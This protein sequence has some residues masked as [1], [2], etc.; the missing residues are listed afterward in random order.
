MFTNRK[1][2]QLQEEICDK[3]VKIY[4]LNQENISLKG[5]VDFLERNMNTAIDDAMN[6]FALEKAEMKGQYEERI[7]M[8]EAEIDIISR[9]NHDANVKWDRLMHYMEY[10]TRAGSVAKE[11]LFQAC[12]HAEKLI[13]NPDSEDNLDTNNQQI[14]AYVNVGS[15]GCD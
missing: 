12:N 14:K 6:K 15:G 8:L 7:R 9:R 1:V 2:E 5:K 13:N 11:R 3:Q 4:R 10:L